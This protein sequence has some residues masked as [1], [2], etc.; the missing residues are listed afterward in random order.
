MI[1][2]AITSDVTFVSNH[3]TLSSFIK[4]HLEEIK[5]N[6]SAF[7]VVTSIVAI[8]RFLIRKV[9]FHQASSF[10][11]K[12]D[13]QYH[14]FIIYCKENGHHWLLH[15]DDV[16]P[17]LPKM[18]TKRRQHFFMHT[19]FFNSQPYLKV[20]RSFQSTTNNRPKGNTT[21]SSFIHTCTKPVTIKKLR[22]APVGSKNNDKKG[23][24]K[25]CP[26]VC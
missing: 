23:V 17:P 12:S 13:S 4:S 9:F 2:T 15:T 20:V 3:F 18:K 24:G 21:V 16:P 14:L 6:I 5:K 19:Y 7:T 25:R 26:R 8:N 10:R 1:L 22:C 11:I